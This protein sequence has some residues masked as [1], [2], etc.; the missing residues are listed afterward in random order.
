[1]INLKGDV[2]N[3]KCLYRECKARCCKPALVTV[4][5]I[6]RISRELDIEPSEFVRTKSENGLYRL[7]GKGDSC[8]F[9]NEDFTCE[10]HKR[11][12]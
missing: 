11:K 8:H 12:V 7:R 2:E 10:L 9:L 1:M 6:K 3:W 4:G 5:D